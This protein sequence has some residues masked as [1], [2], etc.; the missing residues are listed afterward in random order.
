MLT[1]VG[2]EQFIYPSGIQRPE[3]F[4][5]LNYVVRTPSTEVVLN[6][7]AQEFRWVNA[8][9]AMTLDLNLP[10]RKLLVEALNQGLIGHPDG[11]GASF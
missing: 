9:E 5:L 3:H 11:A 7:E 1:V 4:L 2:R 10:T 6:D 8:A